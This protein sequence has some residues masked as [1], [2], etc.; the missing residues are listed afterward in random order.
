MLVRAKSRFFGRNARQAILGVVWWRC[1]RHRHEGRNDGNK[2]GMVM[3]RGE[4]SWESRQR[5]GYR[6]VFGDKLDCM[7][8][9][10]VD[11][12]DRYI[13]PSDADIAKNTVDSSKKG[14]VISPGGTTQEAVFRRA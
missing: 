5:A 1:R 10:R 3:A 2:K 9:W 13:I 7:Y 4:G 8:A 6:I 12:C 14:L 11:A